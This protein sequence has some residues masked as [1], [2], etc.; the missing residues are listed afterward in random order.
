[1]RRLLVALSILL[2]FTGCVENLRIEDISNN[3]VTLY[4]DTEK[5]TGSIVSVSKYRN[6]LWLVN[7]EDEYLTKSH[8]MEI[9]N[10]DRNT[11]YFYQVLS[12]DSNFVLCYFSGVLNFTTSD[13]N[14]YK[15][16]LK[17]KSLKFIDEEVKAGDD[18]SAAITLANNRNNDF[19]DT[20]ITVVF[21]ELGLRKRIG[22][23]DLDDDDEM[24]KQI[25][26][27]I[28]EDT[29]KGEYIAKITITNE[30]SKIRRVK[31]RYITVT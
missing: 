28:P 5:P 26:L 25:Y 2:L 18:V 20:K 24:T 15:Q 29:P 19:K 10:L 8:M 6:G 31:Y 17:I 22:P 14:T 23:F 30:K 16:S 1:M 9:T 21:P 3:K 27:T 13:I 11:L 12:C 4:W 7:Y